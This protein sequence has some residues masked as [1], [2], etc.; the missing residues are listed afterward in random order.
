[1]DGTI[2]TYAANV[3]A[4]S[5]FAQCDAEGNQHVLLEEIVDHKADDQAV[6]FAD[7]FVV[8]NGRQHIRKTTKGWSLCVKWKDGSTS[9]VKLYELKELFP[10]QVAEYATAQSIA[11]EPAFAWWVPYTLKKR[12]R[13]IAVVNQRYLKR[14]H[15]FGIEVPKTIKRALEID[16][17]NGN[18]LWRDA[19]AKEMQA[20][21]IAFKMLEDGASAPPG[22]QL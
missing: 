2:G 16:K 22:Y 20:V 19:I 4:E 9:W 15:K 10:I 1:M 7:R 8:V 18:T 21:R 11:H 3:I 5:M 14:T 6:K 13:I 12:D 17:E